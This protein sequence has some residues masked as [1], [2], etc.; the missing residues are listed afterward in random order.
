MAKF[1]RRA[2]FRPWWAEI[3]PWEFDPPRPYQGTLAEP[4]KAADCYS[5]TPQGVGGSNPPRSAMDGRQRRCTALGWNPSEPLGSGSSNLSP[6]AKLEWLNQAEQLICNQPVAGSIPVSSSKEGMAQL[7]L[8]TGCKPV[9]FGAARF[10]SSV[11]HHDGHCRLGP[12]RGCNPRTLRFD[13]S[14]HLY[15]DVA[16]LGGAPVSYSGGWRFDS[17]RQ[18]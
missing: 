11:F 12:A 18:L 14:A 7:V 8:P 15:A 16:Q 4:G 6:S 17:S 2:R 1:G 13:S 3:C 10:D 5:V 9:L